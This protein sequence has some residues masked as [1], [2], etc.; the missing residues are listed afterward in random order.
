MI[1]VMVFCLSIA[2]W[3]Y[4]LNYSSVTDCLT[5]GKN[6]IWEVFVNGKTVKWVVWKNNKRFSIY[7]SGTPNEPSDD[8]VLDKETG[9]V[10]ARKPYTG[11]LANPNQA[12]TDCNNLALGNRKGW[13][14]S[15]V[16]ELASL[17]DTSV[18]FPGPMLPP[19]HPFID[20]PDGN[21]SP[22]GPYLTATTNTWFSSEAWW[23]VDLIDGDID[24]GNTGFFW[25]V[26]GGQGTPVQ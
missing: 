3:A 20:V 18:S 16:Q 15:T 22:N 2:G 10:W 11:G 23:T 1:V 21:S 7:D 14:L 5:V 24:L 12:N 13:R 17:M 9:L 6:P 8:M 4:A 19:G 25:C 26:R